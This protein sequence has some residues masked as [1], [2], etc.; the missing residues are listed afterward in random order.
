MDLPQTNQ[1]IEYKIPSETK[2]NRDQLKL[3]QLEA[4]LAQEEED[5]S[6]YESVGG[7][8]SR[9]QVVFISSTDLNELAEELDECLKGYHLDEKE[10]SYEL[11]NEQRLIASLADAF[12]FLDQVAAKKGA[13]SALRWLFEELA[14]L[15]SLHEKKAEQHAWSSLACRLKEIKES[16]KEALL[17]S[18]RSL[19]FF[20]KSLLKVHLKGALYLQLKRRYETVEPLRE[21]A[22]LL[23]NAMKERIDRLRSELKEKF[24]AHYLKKSK[25]EELIQTLTALWMQEVNTIYALIDSLL[26]DNEVVSD[27]SSYPLLRGKK[28]LLFTCNFGTG[29][30]IAAEAIQK[31][32][33][34]AQMKSVIYDLSRGALLGRDRM[35]KLFGLLNVK[36]DDHTMNSTDLFN[37]VLAKQLFFLINIENTVDGWIRKIFDQSGTNGVTSAVGLEK[38]SWEKD[39]LRDLI[40]IEQPDQIITTYHMDLNPIFEVSQ[41]FN[42][43]ITHIPTD[44]NMKCSEVFEDKTPTY[45]HFKSTVPNTGIEK[46]LATCSPLLN[47]QLVEDVGIPLRQEFYTSYSKMQRA[48]LRKDRNISSNEK[49][50]YLSAGGNGQSLPHPQ[51][52]AN[53]KSWKI[54]LRILVIA[55]KNIS[56]VEKLRKELQPIDE[57]GLLLRGKNSHVTVEIITHSDRTKKGT[58]EEFFVPAKQIAE[59]LAISDGAIAKAGGL[60]VA[61]LLFNGVPILFDHRKTPL[62]W[63]GFNIKVAEE[64]EMGLCNYTLSSLESDLKTLFQYKKQRKD[65]FYFPSAQETFLNHI[66]KQLLNALA[67]EKSMTSRGVL[68]CELKLLSLVEHQDKLYAVGK[69]AK[70]DLLSI[71]QELLDSDW[72]LKETFGQIKVITAD[73]QSGRFERL[74]KELIKVGMTE[75]QFSIAPAVNGASLSSSLWGRAHHWGDKDDERSKQGRMGCF[76]AHY[77]VIKASY[78]AWCEAQERL[79]LALHKADIDQNEIEEALAEV[80][81]RSRLLVVEDNCGFGQADRDEELSVLEEGIRLRRAL[82]ELPSNWDMFYFVTMADDWGASE[83]VSDDLVKLNYGVL[84]KCYAVQAPFYKVLLDHF[85]SY[86]YSDKPIP[87]IDHVMAELHSSSHCYAPKGKGFC[88]RFSSS[89]MV[90]TDSHDS[91]DWQTG[92]WLYR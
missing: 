12:I 28:A 54:P 70:E 25:K 17:A 26:A 35:R 7:K 53:S 60:S 76:M 49:V 55:G 33:D 58:Q 92:V 10:L 3:K 77:D 41:E 81:A 38:N 91:F 24:F 47:S 62:S 6:S 14:H 4:F 13:S 39:Q 15:Y 65:C 8:K 18:M 44:F 42:L 88:Y 36:Y 59:L 29:H 86:L 85:E 78:E 64:E 37:E 56:Y 63:E 57:E 51:L 80:R 23:L 66:N 75:E 45:R 46:T 2:L 21:E 89:S 22:A 20:Y 84:T 68:A 50:L 11:A 1:V 5:E 79:H 69:K 9:Y 32:L 52:L 30:K 73:A 43:P 40:F 16:E 90:K 72:K 31:M 48:L 82:S 61:E 74:K 27:S 71:A 34:K 87:P 19:G 83:L 67:D